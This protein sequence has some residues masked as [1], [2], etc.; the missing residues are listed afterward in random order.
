MY[1]KRSEESVATGG[2]LAT[3]MDVRRL[4]PVARVCLGQWV[5]N[6]HKVGKALMRG[7]AC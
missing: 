4:V 1:E 6:H 7:I 2:L 5:P 3:V